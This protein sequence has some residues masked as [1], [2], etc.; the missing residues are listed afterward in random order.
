MRSF[1]KY[2]LILGAA[3]LGSAP[4]LAQEAKA[5][6]GARFGSEV[7]LDDGMIKEL[8][9]DK[10][11]ANKAKRAVERVITKHRAEI[12]KALRPKKADAAS[13]REQF[14]MAMK[15]TIAL[16][17][18]ARAALADVLTANQYK[19][20]NQLSLQRLGVLGMTLP[21]VERRLNLSDDQKKQIEKIHE[22]LIKEAQKVIREAFKEAKGDVNA[23]ARSADEKIQS[24]HKRSLDRATAL[25]SAD[26]KKSW[27]D[28]SGHRP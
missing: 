21:R 25:L 2:F 17:E 23:A 24:L 10:E 5:P 11:Q 15:R 1:G 3:L 4:S 8:G 12:Q 14:H 26:Q 22:D 19:R 7:V 13:E 6:S 16:Q 18:D 28:L 27:A 9:L 20:Y